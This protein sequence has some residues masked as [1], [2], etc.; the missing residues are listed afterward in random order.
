MLGLSTKIRNLIMKPAKR[1]SRR[2]FH[3]SIVEELCYIEDPR[4]AVVD[5]SGYHGIERVS[6]KKRQNVKY[7]N[8]TVSCRTLRSS[9][10]NARYGCV[11]K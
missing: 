1:N 10:R 6:N 9:A 5:R 4:K 3:L 7:A 8:A 11:F 2:D